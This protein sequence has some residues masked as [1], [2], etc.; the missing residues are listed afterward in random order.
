LRA[1]KPM[2]K[3]LAESK[4][5]LHYNTSIKE[6]VGEEKIEG[7]VLNTGESVKT[8]GL[9]L[10]IGHVPATKFLEGSGVELDPE[11]YVKVGG[12]Y[13]T[14]TTVPGIFAGGDCVDHRYRQA[15]VAS[16][17][18]VMAALDCEK[19]LTNQQVGEISVS[20][21]QLASSSANLQ[22]QPIG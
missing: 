20:A 3:R 19:W 18:G 2:Q 10:A 8:D 21:G 9:F 14:I 1:S 13:P 4:V 6:V 12:E 11:G 7:L 16:G 22:D 17:M 15:A 5:I